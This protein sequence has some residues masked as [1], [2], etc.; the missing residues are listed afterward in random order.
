MSKVFQNIVAS[1]TRTSGHDQTKINILQLFHFV[2]NHINVD[3]ATLLCNFLPRLE[4]DYHS[5]KDDIPLGKKRKQS[6]RE[7]SSP[8]KSLKVT[9]KQKPKTISIPPPSDDRE[10]DEIAEATL[11][12][13]TMHKTALAAEAQENAAKVQEKLAE[14]EI[15]KMVKKK[16]DEQKDDNAEKTNVAKEKNNDATG[17][18]GK[19]REVLDHC[20][21]VVPELTMLILLKGEKRAKRYFGN[22]KKAD[23]GMVRNVCEWKNQFYRGR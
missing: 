15:E 5:I 17:S 12:S 2:V 11:L 16:D 22:D 21:N 9:I 23:E 7:T 10:G 1:L 13:I 3:Y 18:R 4:E 8:R 6:A 20:N 19:I 14:E